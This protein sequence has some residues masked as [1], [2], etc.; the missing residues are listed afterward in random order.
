VE[1]LHETYSV[2]CMG[3]V[4]DGNE[5][6]LNFKILFHRKRLKPDSTNALKHSEND[7]R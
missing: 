2:G 3:M 6:F 7:L 5:S 1:H 4:A